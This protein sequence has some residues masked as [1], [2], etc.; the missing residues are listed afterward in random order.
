MINFKIC[1][2][3]KK[4]KK[5][6][7]VPAELFT[8]LEL[9]RTQSA[10]QR[11]AGMKHKQQMHSVLNGKSRLTFAQ[12]QKIELAANKA[13]ARLRSSIRIDAVKL[14]PHIFTED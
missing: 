10:L 13:A 5:I 6:Y 11:A 3:K 14:V 9:L 1:D 2:M 7:N 12:A 4:P 8:A